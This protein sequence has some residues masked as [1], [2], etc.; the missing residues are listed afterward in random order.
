[1]AFLTKAGLREKWKGGTAQFDF[2]KETRFSPAALDF[3]RTWQLDV[4][5]GGDR[6]A[7]AGAQ[8][9]HYSGDL[10]PNSFARATHRE[11]K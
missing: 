2:P 8:V 1:M 6:S 5:V 9:H 4:R 10:A 11:G 3:I 7:F